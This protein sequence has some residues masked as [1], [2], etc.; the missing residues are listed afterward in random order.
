MKTISS[1]DVSSR[2]SSKSTKGKEIV[3][4]EKHPDTEA[5]K[6][7]KFQEMAAESLI[8]Q[9]DFDKNLLKFNKT[10]ND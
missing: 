6:E 1:I 8:R 2:D 9:N 10:Q 5:I 3:E 7:K 4:E